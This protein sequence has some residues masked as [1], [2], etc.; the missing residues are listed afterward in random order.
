MPPSSAGERHL[1]VR[2]AAVDGDLSSVATARGAVHRHRALR[3]DLAGGRRRGRR[4]VARSGRS[5]SRARPRRAPAGRPCAAAEPA[6]SP[7]RA[8]RA[9]PSRRRPG[10]AWAPRGL[11]RGAAGRRGRGGPVAPAGAGRA[12]RRRR[13]ASGSSGAGAAAGAGAGSCAATAV[14][15]TVRRLHRRAVGAAGLRRRG[16]RQGRHRASAATGAGAALGAGGGRRQRRS[17]ER[18]AWRSRARRRGRRLG[19][20]RDRRSRR[21]SPGARLAAGALGGGGRVGSVAACAWIVVAGRCARHAGAPCLVAGRAVAAARRPVLPR[22][23]VAWASSSAA[24]ASPSR[25]SAGGAER[26]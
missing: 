4:V 7:A 20:Q 23:G 8:G 26:G 12:R 5:A 6:P 16:G 3:S 1:G 15:A 14:A 2:D 18:G 9:R 13:P 10:A 25:R 17:G 11:R 22:R 21:A 24:K 19:R